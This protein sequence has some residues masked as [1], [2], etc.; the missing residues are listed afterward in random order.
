[1]NMRKEIA[2]NLK[3]GEKVVFELKKDVRRVL[4]IFS[5][6]PDFVMTASFIDQ[7]GY[8]EEGDETLIIADGKTFETYIVTPETEIW[9]LE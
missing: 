4:S 7:N 3:S 8:N 9:I 5:D 1:M 6:I 2:K